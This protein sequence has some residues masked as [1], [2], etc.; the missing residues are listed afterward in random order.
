MIKKI[1]LGA[2]ITLNLV[3]LNTH[4]QIKK[5]NPELTLF[6][7]GS[8]NSSMQTNLG[9]NS[10]SL[11]LVNN[12]FHNMNFSIDLQYINGNGSKVEDSPSEV[13]LGWSINSAGYV[14]LTEGYYMPSESEETQVLYPILDYL[15]PANW[16]TVDYLSSLLNFTPSSNPCAI[17]NSKSLYNDSKS[18]ISNVFSFNFFG[19]SGNIF[20]D[21]NN[22]PKL[23]S[24]N[25]QCLD[26]KFEFI[27]DLPENQIGEKVDYNKI[28]FKINSL[29]GY[30][31]N[32][33][34]SKHYNIG[35]Y[36]ELAD[37]FVKVKDIEVGRITF[38]DCQGNQFIFG[39]TANS[40]ELSRRG[41]NLMTN[42]LTIHKIS[43][44]PIKW[45]LTKVI[46]SNGEQINYSYN[47]GDVIYKSESFI[48]FKEG[49]Y[50]VNNAS[51][52]IHGHRYFQGVSINGSIINPSYLN[53]IN[54]KDYNIQFEYS[55]SKQLLRN[56]ST[57]IDKKVSHNK[58][59]FFFLY[60]DI[61]GTDFRNVDLNP[62]Q[63]STIKISNNN[64]ITDKISFEYTKNNIERLKLLSVNRQNNNQNYQ[65]EYEKTMLPNYDSFKEDYYGYA[66]LNSNPSII[67]GN[68]FSNSDDEETISRNSNM[69]FE[70]KND[71]N[72]RNE[73]IKN[74]E[75][76]NISKYPE[77]LKKVIYPTKGYLEFTYEANNYSKEAINY[78]FDIKNYS[79][80]FNGGGV[81]VK[82][83][84]EYDSDG[85]LLTSISYKY[86]NNYNSNKQTT[87][88]SGVLNHKPTYFEYI[89]SNQNLNGSCTNMPT[90][91]NL[92]Y[93][94]WSSKDIFPANYLR[95]N[96]LTYSEIVEIDDFD[97]SYTIY[98]YSN[99]DNGVH[100]LP[101]I[102]YVSTFNQ[103]LRDENNNQNSSWKNYDVISK[104]ILRGLLINTKMYDTSSKL[105]KEINYKYKYD[106]SNFI[107]KITKR[108]EKLYNSASGDLEGWL[109]IASKIYVGTPLLANKE[110]IVYDN[111][112][113]QKKLES[114]EYHYKYNLITQRTV[115]FNDI[116]LREKYKYPFDYNEVSYK[117]MIQKNY[118][119][120]VIEK[121]SFINDFLFN[122][123]INSYTINSSNNKMYVPIQVEEYGKNNTLDNTF[124]YDKYDNIGNI[125]S[126]TNNDGTNILYLWSYNKNK[127]VAELKNIDY[128]SL[129]SRLGEQYLINISN[130]ISWTEAQEI[131]FNTKL[132][133]LGT[134]ILFET[135]FYNDKGLLKSRYSNGSLVFTYTYDT[136]NR[137]T[138]VTDGKGFIISDYDYNV[139]Y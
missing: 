42:E 131:E 48:D 14:Q 78:P 50:Y 74:R 113:A 87:V 139:I 136:F 83:R 59:I 30:K 92:D 53:S 29:K 98:N 102:N 44:K 126:Q 100:D 47:R 2:L 32:D 51:T 11:N 121:E 15:Q 75:P 16:S 101:I 21:E 117:N 76:E 36:P 108:N 72:K 62:L 43:V 123:T 86:V 128:N 25:N 1:L 68:V 12:K 69:N 94:N 111:N 56:L 115:L 88:S 46:L 35:H 40:I 89:K 57:L 125:L 95:G 18:L 38:Y 37:D 45:N 124:Y 137:L 61:R 71:I 9:S 64:I 118:I 66:K 17:K 85:T 54:Y 73:Y 65:F 27:S 13:G 41:H 93:W 33:L 23:Q 7:S 60:N 39:G 70:F 34:Y 122:R 112:S 20:F 107:R 120:P 80:N 103:Y 119:S 52:L 49:H 26:V 129:V 96:H 110:E 28:K 127:I 109:F 5:T 77:I 3:T 4:G 8:V 130:R 10:F 55:K 106:E 31:N 134:D 79:L 104:A 19:Y 63:L 105:V 84:S 24:N 132:L 114:L 90:I 91:N 135:V 82:N 6:S 81:R 58:S 22:V 67:R 99:F 133:S 138:R 116:K 97:N